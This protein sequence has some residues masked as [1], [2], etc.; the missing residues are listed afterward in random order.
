MSTKGFE[1]E[2][3]QVAP[4]PPTEEELRELR[5][6]ERRFQKE[7]P[8]RFQ[9]DQRNYG[10]RDESKWFV[11]IPQGEM[12]LLGAPGGTGKSWMFLYW[13]H[14]ISKRSNPDTGKHWRVM[15]WLGEDAAP[16]TYERLCALDAGYTNLEEP[17]E[18]VEFIWEQGRPLYRAERFTMDQVDA[19]GERR[20][21]TASDVKPTE[22]MTYLEKRIAA[23]KPDIL[24]LDPLSVLG[25]IGFETDNE[26]C[27]KF[28]SD[29]RD[30]FRKFDGLTV[31]A[32]HH[33]NKAGRD[34][35]SAASLRGSSALTDGFRHA[36]TLRLIGQLEDKSE[37]LFLRTV[38]ANYVAPVNTFY[39]RVFDKGTTTI[40]PM[41][42]KQV[43]E[44]FDRK[45]LKKEI[46]EDVGV[47]LKGQNETTGGTEK[48]K[49][50][51]TKAPTNPFEG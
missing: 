44:V 18:N 46:G 21:I 41:D 15:L 24:F 42:R 31:L 12:T 23:F 51:T 14:G 36:F 39:K 17:P 45:E 37:V 32:S 3:I 10:G 29:M 8:R 22:G 25:P 2:V 9:L 43:D 4:A 1:E 50:A 11:E 28:V 49:P 35:D 7:K 47:A 5:K 33:S 40:E 38:K 30:R 6:K 26:V 20:R 48:N 13:A 16:I 19:K 34:G 27:A